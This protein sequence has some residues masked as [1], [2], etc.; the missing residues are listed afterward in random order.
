VLKNKLMT[1]AIDAVHRDPGRA[2]ALYPNRRVARVAG[3]AV[4]AERDHPVSLRDQ[5]VEIRLMLGAGDAVV[6]LKHGT[7]LPL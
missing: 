1:V 6:G 5:I 3:V 4:H 2:A 7:P